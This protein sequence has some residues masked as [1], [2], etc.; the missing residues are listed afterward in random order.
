MYY[1][2][3]TSVLVTKSMLIYSLKHWINLFKKQSLFFKVVMN[4]DQLKTVFSLINGEIKICMCLYKYRLRFV[5][6][7]FDFD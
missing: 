6:N 2:L 3:S 5:T 4:F 7:N 1:C